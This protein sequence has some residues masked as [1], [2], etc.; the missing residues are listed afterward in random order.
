MKNLTISKKLVV[1]FGI[2]LAAMLVI[3]AASLFSI[4]NLG[5]DMQQYGNYT[6]PVT[7]ATWNIRRDLVSAE[8]YLLEAMVDTDAQSMKDDLASADKDTADIQTLLTGLIDNKLDQG[9]SDKLATFK[10][11]LSD[12]AAIH[13]NIV[14]LLSNKSTE[15]TA[16]AYDL[17]LSQYSPA[18]EKASTDIV[19]INTI[20]MNEADQQKIQAQNTQRTAWI[21]LIAAFA[22]ALPITVFI[23]FAIRKSILNPVKEIE[24]VYAEMAKGNMQVEITYDSR[25]EM[26]EM[27]KSIRRTNALLS[28]YINDISNKLGQLSSGDMRIAVD[29]DYIG[30]F[31]AIK[32]AMESTA[33]A[34]NHTLSTINIAAEQVSTGASQVSS[35][36][37]ALAAGSS[38]QASSVEELTVSITKIAEQAAENSTNVKT[39]TQYVDQANAD[40]RD[41]DEHMKHLTEAM[42][43]ISASSN[44]ITNITET[45]EDI[46]FQT[47]ILA[48][49]AAIEAARAGNAGRGFAVV[50][51]EV[52]NLAAKSAEAAKQTAELIQRS[53]A[54]VAEG[55]QITAQTALILQ[56]VE[57][58]TSQV[59]QIINKINLASSDQAIAIDQ[60]KQ[61]LSQVSSVVQTNAAT[62]EENSATSE[63]MSAQAVTLREEVGK[64]KLDR[65][66]EADSAP[67]ISPR[68]SLPKEKRIVLE[69]P[70]GFGKY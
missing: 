37:Q 65:H 5:Q 44:Q 26:G 48:L 70:S 49:N 47:N 50:A 51:D 20:V 28:S 18:F 57:K 21:M 27:A 68:K 32:Q 19:E 55:S 2:V 15:N 25:D 13:K 53:A 64:F 8:R 11:D 22:I 6:L 40:V 24:N 16:K 45:I 30:D 36:A 58:K 67:T 62:A 33:T 31:A 61:G 9:L 54:T 66:Y 52:R 41:G 38:E 23:I 3:T 35:G 1:G 7:T 39:A 69:A 56:N 43:N 4:N 60:I 10:Q 12:A 63:E 14:D 17:F 42:S 34:L 29:L 59:N 46:A